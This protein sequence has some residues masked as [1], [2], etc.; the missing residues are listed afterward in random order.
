ML[1]KSIVNNTIEIVFVNKN[2][3]NVPL[4]NPFKRRCVYNIVYKSGNTCKLRNLCEITFCL[5]INICLQYVNHSN[6]L[7]MGTKN[8]Q[9]YSKNSVLSCD[10]Q[11]NKG[12]LT[13]RCFANY[14]SR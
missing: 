13:I 2:R 3:D 12:S 7:L 5:Y 10:V 8:N 6:N 11:T 1:L 9:F 14:K 4:K